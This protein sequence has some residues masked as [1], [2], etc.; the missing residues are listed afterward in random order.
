MI[1]LLGLTL[2]PS[3]SHAADFCAP[4]ANLHS[5]I[6]FCEENTTYAKYAIDC[7]DQFRAFADAKSAELRKVLSGEIALSNGDAQNI[8]FKTTQ[9]AYESTDAALAET[10][11]V[12]SHARGEIVAYGDDFVAPFSYPWMDLGPFPGLHD[13]TV[14]E[15]F[16]SARCYKDNMESIERT[17]AEF[18]RMISQLKDTRTK[19]AQLH[20]SSNG[21]ELKLDELGSLASSISGGP[22]PIPSGKSVNPASSITGIAQSKAKAGQLIENNKQ[23][24][25]IQAEAFAPGSSAI[26]AR[27]PGDR[28]IPKTDYQNARA[29]SA[30]AVASGRTTGQAPN[31]NKNYIKSPDADSVGAALWSESNKVSMPNSGLELSVDLKDL[32][33][34]GN[35]E[36]VVTV[37]LPTPQTNSPNEFSA[38]PQ[39]RRPRS[40]ASED[41]PSQSGPAIDRAN[42]SIFEIVHNRYRKIKLFTNAP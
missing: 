2:F 7:R 21:R 29:N 15:L 35:Q 22:A 32:S 40:P 11:K 6:F 20:K 16:R 34:N 8:Q 10:I 5:H 30:P 4:L 39:N 24:Q 25:Q 14:Q 28:A 36:M 38:S 23:G 31:T 1:L 33:K 9:V 3:Q 18:D 19:A 41:S 27:N 12:G 26:S 17:I 37:D 13:P 42:I